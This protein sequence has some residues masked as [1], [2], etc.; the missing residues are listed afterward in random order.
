MKELQEIDRMATLKYIADGGPSGRPCSY[1]IA[2]AKTLFKNGLVRKARHARGRASYI[3]TDAGL[4]KI[5]QEP[6]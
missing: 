2:N 3:V 6:A 4:R 1:C 5:N